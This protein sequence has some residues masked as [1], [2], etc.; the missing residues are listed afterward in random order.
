MY[1]KLPRVLCRSET[2]ATRKRAICSTIRWTV[3]G[4]FGCLHFT[5]TAQKRELSRGKS[6]TFQ[7]STR[8]R[9]RAGFPPRTSR[10][11]PSL[12]R[13]KLLLA[14]HP[15]QLPPP[16]HRPCPP[17]PPFASGPPA[18]AFPLGCL[19]LTSTTARV[20]TF[21]PFPPVCVSNDMKD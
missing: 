12:G 9:R 4:F 20:D 10:S 7:A 16:L 8:P 14:R 3:N 19:R 15:P 18:I 17:H 2:I 5:I 21:D 13:H 6:L 1:R 11:F